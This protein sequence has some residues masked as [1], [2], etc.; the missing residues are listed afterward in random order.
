MSNNTFSKNNAAHEVM[1]K[2][3]VDPERPQMTM[4]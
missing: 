4:L 2:K 3:M 1:W